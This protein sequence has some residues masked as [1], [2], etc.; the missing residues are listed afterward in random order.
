MP[1]LLCGPELR[2]HL[3]TFTG[4]AVPRLAVLSINEIPHSIDLKS[5]GVVGIGAQEGRG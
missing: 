2:R 1:V 5:F 4:R 3:K